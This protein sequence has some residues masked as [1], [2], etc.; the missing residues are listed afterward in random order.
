MTIPKSQILDSSPG[1]LIGSGM[2]GDCSLQD[3]AKIII[4]AR[5]RDGYDPGDSFVS[6]R[7]VDWQP[8]MR[9]GFIYFQNQI[10]HCALLACAE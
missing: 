9:D 10:Q 4:S 2:A 6:T 1:N 8:N 3:P 7:K 5:E